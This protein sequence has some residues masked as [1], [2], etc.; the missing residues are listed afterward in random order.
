[1]ACWA[2][3]LTTLYPYQC[4]SLFM[5]GSS[6]WSCSTCRNEFTTEGARDRHSCNDNTEDDRPGSCSNKPYADCE[7]DIS[8]DKH[9]KDEV[10]VQGSNNTHGMF[11]PASLHE[12]E[13][14]HGLNDVSSLALTLNHKGLSTEKRLDVDI[15]LDTGGL[16][17]NTKGYNPDPYLCV[18]CKSAFT[19]ISHCN[20]NIITPTGKRCHLCSRCENTFRLLS[21]LDGLTRVVSDREKCYCTH[22]NRRF[23]TTALLEEHIESHTQHPYGCGI[24]DLKFSNRQKLKSHMRSHP[25]FVQCKF[26]QCSEVNA[27]RRNPEKQMIQV[28]AQKEANIT[29]GQESK[30][31]PALPMPDH[32]KLQE[33]VS[34]SNKVTDPPRTKRK[35]VPDGEKHAAPSSTHTSTTTTSTQGAGYMS[36]KQPKVALINQD[37]D[38]GGQSGPVHKVMAQTDHQTPVQD[39]VNV[40]SDQSSVPLVAIP[41]IPVIMLQSPISTQ[42]LQNQG[43]QFSSLASGK[44]KLMSLKSINEENCSDSK[45]IDT[46]R[47]HTSGKGIDTHKYTSVKVMDKNLSAKVVETEKVPFVRVSDE[48]KYSCN[49]AIGKEKPSSVKAINEKKRTSVEIHTLVNSIDLKKHTAMQAIDMEKH[50]APK[51]TDTEKL[52][53]GEEKNTNIENRENHACQHCDKVFGSLAKLQ[54]HIRFQPGVRQ[55]ACYPCDIVFPNEETMAAHRLIHA[56]EKSFK[57]DTCGEKFSSRPYLTAHEN[58]H[59]ERHIPCPHCE[60]KFELLSHLKCHL[61]THK[62]RTHL[63]SECGKVL[64]SQKVLK[65]HMRIHT[66]ERPFECPYCDKKFKTADTLRSHNRMHTG[67]KRYVC[68]V[69]KKAFRESGTLVCHMTN[70]TGEKSFVCKFCNKSF[71]R[72]DYLKK[73][74]L[75]HTGEKPH[76]CRFCDKQFTQKS[77]LNSHMKAVHAADM[78]TTKY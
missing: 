56:Q 59:R 51:G 1:M 46:E 23:V 39:S 4:L 77:N 64:S 15:E 18:F 27:D 40:A 57:C 47:L 73:H 53:L 31:I 10:S 50:T 2:S 60:K 41:V 9:N 65:N 14:A 52:I 36:R 11:A 48:E 5:T 30:A 38:K 21:G 12:I 43:L 54:L 13:D 66:N 61:V 55:F 71:S 75:F 7:M 17:G 68:K 70:H 74:V 63:C 19:S 49:K 58:I 24:C 78:S 33:M 28:L 45:G 22:C 26:N 69:C 76:S 35:A 37:K 3:T 25:D 67:E 72:L 8:P 16:A 6:K 34:V 32:K 20:S 42:V 62:E 44:E 29:V